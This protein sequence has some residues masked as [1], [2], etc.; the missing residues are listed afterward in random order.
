MVFGLRHGSPFITLCRQLQSV[1]VF[2]HC[3]NGVFRSHPLQY[4]GAG[5]GLSHCSPISTGR[6]LF[7][8]TYSSSY[9]TFLNIYPRKSLSFIAKS[10]ESETDMITFIIV[11]NGAE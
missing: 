1:D 6:P 5:D 11:G 2:L 10:K 8:L 7:L 3:I 9:F 4:K